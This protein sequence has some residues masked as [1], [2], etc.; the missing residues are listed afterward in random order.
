[1]TKIRMNFI[2]AP[3][4]IG[5]IPKVM[6]KELEH[7]EIRDT[8]QTIVLLRLARI[9]RR[10]LETLGDLLSLNLHW[11]TISQRWCENLSKEKKNN[12]H[13]NRVDWVLQPW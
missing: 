3:I 10:I 2:L 13:N 11:E 8:I 5:T 6:V 9:L 4:V 12:N 1:M 7:L